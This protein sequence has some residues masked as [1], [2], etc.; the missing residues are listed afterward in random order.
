MGKKI[1]HHDKKIKV[2]IYSCKS[3]GLKNI[4]RDWWSHT[5]CFEFVK[6]GKAWL[7]ID[8]VLT[9]RR[10]EEKSE[11]LN[12]QKREGKKKPEEELIFI[13]HF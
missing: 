3:Q 7:I 8:K 9:R 13:E 2:V 6:L 4:M 12:N 1:K 5:S 11:E 10:G